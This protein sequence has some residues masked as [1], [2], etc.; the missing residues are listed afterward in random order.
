MYLWEVIVCSR[1]MVHYCWDKRPAQYKR[2]VDSLLGCLWSAARTYPRTARK[3]Q[4]ASSA[5]C[6]IPLLYTVSDRGIQAWSVS[7][8]VHVWGKYR[9]QAHRSGVL[10]QVYAG[11]ERRKMHLSLEQVKGLATSLGSASMPTEYNTVMFWK[12]SAF[13]Q[14]IPWL[15]SN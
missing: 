10:D 7:E 14:I 8:H 12:V 3:G 13:W 6:S 1:G 15:Q 9:T 5:S 4:L 2:I 11:G